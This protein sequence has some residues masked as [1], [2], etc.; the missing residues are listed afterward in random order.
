MRNRLVT[1][2]S[3]KRRISTTVALLLACLTLSGCCAFLSAREARRLLESLPVFPGTERTTGYTTGWPDS[4]PSAGVIYTVRAK[5]Q[6][7]MAFYKS[8]MPSQGWVLEREYGTSG[9]HGQGTL[10]FGKGR[11]RCHILIRGQAEPY[12]LDVN[13][14]AP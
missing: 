3:V 13:V 4:T 14:Y 8:E 6:E 1:S 11:F 9:L 10:I 5:P 2:D 12:D 7:I